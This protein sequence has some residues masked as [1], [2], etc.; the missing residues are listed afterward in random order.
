VVDAARDDDNDDVADAS[1]SEESSLDGVSNNSRTASSASMLVSNL[2]TPLGALLRFDFDDDEL[3]ATGVRVRAD[4]MF[5]VLCRKFHALLGLFG[6]PPPL[7]ER[8]LAIFPLALN[9]CVVELFMAL[10]SSCCRSYSS[11]ACKSCKN[12]ASS[13]CCDENR[14]S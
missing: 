14:S 10:R 7:L 11:G 9:A 8:T 3:L 13:P 4:P 12:L 1:L 2:L 6:A 5:G